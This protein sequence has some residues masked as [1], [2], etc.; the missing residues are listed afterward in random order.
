[1]TDTEIIELY[2]N[3]EQT[4]ITQSANQYGRYCYSIAYGILRN[5][6]DSEECITDTWYRAWEAIPPQRPNILS[7]FFGKIT[8]NLAFNRYKMY[9]AQKR[10]GSEMSLVLHELEECIPSVNTVEQ[11]IADNDLEV[12]INTFLHNTPER[13]CNIFLLRYWYNKSLA[14]I[15]TQL[16]MKENNVKTILFR[17]RQKLKLFLE[18][19]GVSI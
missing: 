16:S 15:A 8:R 14:E 6:E 17:C 13:D 18:K 10:G 1:M 11:A 5:N 3:R 9:R 7:L 19:E 2:W 4:A 12:L